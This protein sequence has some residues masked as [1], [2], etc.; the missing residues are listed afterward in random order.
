MRS[1]GWASKGLS[2]SP[3]ACVFKS[4]SISPLSQLQSSRRSDMMLAT[5]LP[6]VLPT[7]HALTTSAEWTIGSGELWFWG[8]GL[9]L[10]WAIRVHLLYNQIGHC[11]DLVRSCLP[12]GRQVGRAVPW[13][14]KRER[15]LLWLKKHKSMKRQNP[16]AILQNV[17][18]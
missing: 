4:R 5:S 14:S 3:E 9:G 13:E 10:T 8:E 2:Y 11:L 1:R 17:C 6:F 15:A 18:V 12:T 16:H 7:M